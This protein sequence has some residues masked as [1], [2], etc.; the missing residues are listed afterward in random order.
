MRKLFGTIIGLLL[1]AGVV[2]A[3]GIYG[4]AEFKGD[5]TYYGEMYQAGNANVTTINTVN[6]WEEVDNFS[7]G[8][9]RGITFADSDLTISAGSDGTYLVIYTVSADS[10]VAAKDFEMAISIDDGIQSECTTSRTFAST[11][12]GN[13]GGQCILDLTATDVIKLEVRNTTDDNN[14]TVIDSNISLHKI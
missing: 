14:V 7:T 4:S 9:V 2:Y 12:T 6:V 11:T 1:L 5:H 13:S 10:A 8:D 3:S